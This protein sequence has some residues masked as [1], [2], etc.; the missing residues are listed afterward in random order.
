M[1][2]A[3]ALLSTWVIQIQVSRRGALT[4]LLLHPSLLPPKI[5]KNL[6]K[7]RD[8][9]HLLKA[10][11]HWRSSALTVKWDHPQLLIPG[12]LWWTSAHCYCDPWPSRPCP[13]CA[14]Q[15]LH[16]AAHTHTGRS[17]LHSQLPQPHLPP[18]TQLYHTSGYTFLKHPQPRTHLAA[19][20]MFFLLAISLR[21]MCGRV[22]YSATALEGNSVSHTYPKSRARCTASPAEGRARYRCCNVYLLLGDQEN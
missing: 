11:F 18:G 1:L 10:A 5:S 12:V 15:Q 2:P 20:S 16:G 8:F 4:Q 7:N 19:S 9:S 22:R 6:V 14:H 21:P 17:A 13:P 3:R